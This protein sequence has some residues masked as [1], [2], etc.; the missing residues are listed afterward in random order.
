MYTVYTALYP[1]PSLFLF[2]STFI[3]THTYTHQE[4]FRFC[5]TT[6]AALG[7][8]PMSACS[9]KT[10]RTWAHGDPWTEH[11]PTAAKAPYQ[12]SPE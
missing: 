4:C 9:Q 7:E 8:K 10:F 5:K 12:G 6:V 2:P 1:F 11:M 3:Y